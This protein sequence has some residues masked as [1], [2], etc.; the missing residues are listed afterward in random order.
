M[1]GL[2]RYNSRLITFYNARRDLLQI[3]DGKPENA[4]MLEHMIAPNIDFRRE[5]KHPL[6]EIIKRVIDKLP[7]GVSPKAEKSNE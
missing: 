2:F 5:P 3:W 4:S 7:T 6:E 1:I